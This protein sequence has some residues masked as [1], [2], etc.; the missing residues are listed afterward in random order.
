M[1][2]LIRHLL[3]TAAI[4]ARVSATVDESIHK[5]PALLINTAMTIIN[6][7]LVSAANWASIAAVVSWSFTGRATSRTG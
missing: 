1:I 4:L 3:L 5:C 7:P 2:M 6:S